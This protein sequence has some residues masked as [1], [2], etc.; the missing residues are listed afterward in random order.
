MKD[1]IRIP[2]GGWG[3]SHEFRSI[4]HLRFTIY[5]TKESFYKATALA[6]AVFV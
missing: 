6:S 4:Y 2:P 1:K 3:D 5:A